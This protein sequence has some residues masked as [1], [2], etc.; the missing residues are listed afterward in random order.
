MKTNSGS[1]FGSQSVQGQSLNTG[2][3]RYVS[4]AVDEAE[5]ADDEMEEEDNVVHKLLVHFPTLSP[6]LVR[7]RRTEKRRAMK[8]AEAEEAAKS[9]SAA[10]ASQ[11]KV[12]LAIG[13]SPHWWKR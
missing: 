5:H 9:S 7:T 2:T 6:D 13:L 11:A 12:Q 3:N 10:S 4:K 8:K 1:A